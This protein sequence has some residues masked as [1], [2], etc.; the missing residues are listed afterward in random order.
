VSEEI[1]GISNPFS[2][3]ISAASFMRELHDALKEV[4]FTD[5]QA[6]ELVKVLIPVMSA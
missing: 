5:D 6:L 1:P 2:Q 3:F 4:G